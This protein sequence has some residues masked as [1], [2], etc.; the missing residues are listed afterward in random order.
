MGDGEIVYLFSSVS[1][2]E[3]K[4]LAYAPLA[5][6]KSISTYI[7]AD[8]RLKIALHNLSSLQ[9]TLLESPRLKAHHGLRLLPAHTNPV[10]REA[11]LFHNSVLISYVPFA[12]LPGLDNIPAVRIGFSQ[13]ISGGLR[14]SV[15]MAGDVA[16]SV[17]DVRVF[18]RPEVHERNISDVDERAG[19]D[20]GWNGVACE[21]AVGWD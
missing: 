5:N 18:V 4:Y 1:G 11:Y 12:G 9:Q 2:K 3:M 13:D 8:A 19:T 21:D 14:W 16:L 15:P 10:W 6:R 17:R 7:D 20:R